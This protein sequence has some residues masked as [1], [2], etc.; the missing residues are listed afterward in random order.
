MTSGR[1]RSAG[2]VFALVLLLAGCGDS[3]FS[4]L[5]D[6]RDV[7]VRFG[8]S[9]SH[10]SP[11][12]VIELELI[13]RTERVE[14]LSALTVQFR[15]PTDSNYLVEAVE[16]TPGALSASGILSVPVPPEVED[17]V[18]WLDVTGWR[19]S[20]ELFAE[21][22]QVFIAEELPA[23]RQLFLHPTRPVVDSSMLALAVL[24]VP[25]DQRP[26]L[27]WFLAGDLLAEGYLEEGFDQMILPAGTRAG[28]YA[29]R[30]D[31]LPWG[32]DEG[33]R[34]VSIE[35]AP[36]TARAELFV[37]A[38]FDPGD[39]LQENESL[40]WYPLQGHLRSAVRL[41]PSLDGG[42]LFPEGTPMADIS[43]EVYLHIL[44]NVLGYFLPAEST[45]AIP[46]P[47]LSELEK[48]QSLEIEI[49]VPPGA[50][51]RI[52]TLKAREDLSFSLWIDHHGSVQMDPLTEGASDEATDESME[53][54]LEKTSTEPPESSQQAISL[55]LQISHSG[56]V[57]WEAQS[58]SGSV[59]AGGVVMEREFSRETRLLV[60]GEGSAPLLVGAIALR[61]PAMDAGS[62]DAAAADDA[63]TDT[64]ADDD[65]T[66][67]A[68]S[69]E[70][71]AGA[72]ANEASDAAEEDELEDDTDLPEAQ[73]RAGTSD[74]AVDS[75]NDDVDEV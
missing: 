58:E 74:S 50:G 24:D 46:V 1:F 62:A 19:G 45:L 4:S 43:E 51:G 33:V 41:H 18:Y 61:W 37:Q 67:T 34:T 55:T 14:A 12:G 54:P 47:I 9:G 69:A 11:S 25:Q 22:R 42:E 71:A 23:M 72:E 39:L 27:R 70:T 57:V 36:V 60:G 3:L 73:T 13:Y 49:V 20:I 30:L 17:G 63:A 2:A 35:L 56:A 32:P 29:V 28:A 15:S 65:A 10:V 59:G 6:P 38:D 7:E 16:L 8:A 48:P 52:L 21:S 53:N 44:S 64:A 5:E 26:W 66:D 68:D 31:V 40:Q 75:E